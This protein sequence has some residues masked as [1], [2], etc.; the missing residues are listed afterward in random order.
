MLGISCRTLRRWRQPDSLADR[1]KGAVRAP[2]RRQLTPED[3]ERILEVCNRPEFQSL[4]PSQIVPRLADR[5]EYIA[6]ESSIYRVLRAH[7]QVNR[8]G[9]HLAC[10]LGALD[11]LSTPNIAPGTTPTRSNGI[12]PSAPERDNSDA[13]C[14]LAPPDGSNCVRSY[15]DANL[16]AESVRSTVASP[17]PVPSTTSTRTRTRTTTT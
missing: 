14:P 11:W 15:C 4:P 3:R 12:A 7:D 5:G 17:L 8:Q 2:N 6:S 13:G 9:R 16:C 1:R 10:T